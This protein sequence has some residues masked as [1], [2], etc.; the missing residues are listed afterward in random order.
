MILS[1]GFVK[2]C[3]RN[4]KFLSRPHVSFTIPSYIRFLWGIMTSVINNCDEEKQPVSIKSN[5]VQSDSLIVKVS[6][7]IHLSA[8]AESYKH[9]AS[10]FKFF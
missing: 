2:K 10:I 4:K 9:L 6:S 1:K 8:V 7:Q 5:I 3:I